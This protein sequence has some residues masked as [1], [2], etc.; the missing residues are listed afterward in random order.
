MFK[1]HQRRPENV[2][3][4]LARGVGKDVDVL[5]GGHGAASSGFTRLRWKPF[6]LSGVKPFWGQVYTVY[7]L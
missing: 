2:Q 1:L 6:N 4:A 3:T 5:L 7:L